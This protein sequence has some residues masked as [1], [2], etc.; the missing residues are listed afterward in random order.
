L[1]RRLERIDAYAENIADL[2]AAFEQ[3][4][5]TP[6]L[7]KPLVSSGTIHIKG[8][9]T[10]WD[11]VTPS[12]SVLT[13][14]PASLKIFYPEQRSLEIYSVSSGLSRLAATPLPRLKVVREQFWI[15]ECKVSEM[16]NPPP[17]SAGAQVA[18]L[19]LPKSDE[20]KKYVRQVRVLLDEPTRGKD[21]PQDAK[22]GADKVAYGVARQVEV[23][24]ADGDR[25]VVCFKDA[26]INTGLTD[27]ELELSVPDGTR[28]SRPLEAGSTPTGPARKDPK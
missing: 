2:T 9:K 20:L 10:R 19:L 24:D 4:R 23:T 12:P 25:T 26:R 22:N 13:I 8:S 7:R 21:D 15:S 5:S 3:R 18:L 27:A 14:D 28:I 16:D 11:T 6:L 17:A 1:I